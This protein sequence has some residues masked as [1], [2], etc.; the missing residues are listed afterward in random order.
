VAAKRADAAGV[1]EEMNVNEAVNAAGRKSL[2]PILVQGI[3][4]EPNQSIDKLFGELFDNFLAFLRTWMVSMFVERATNA[5]PEGIMKVDV[6]DSGQG[7]SWDATR[8]WGVLKVRRP[9]KG[10]E[11]MAVAREGNGK[12]A[13]SRY[14]AMA[15]VQ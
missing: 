10:T 13:V 7:G 2:T 11:V 12:G 14:G 1:A 6:E 5:M 9:K 8:G 4:L 3:S 15:A